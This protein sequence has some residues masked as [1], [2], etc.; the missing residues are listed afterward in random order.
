M[1]E[2]TTC[3]Y[4]ILIVKFDVPITLHGGP[5]FYTFTTV[6]KCNLKDYTYDD[7]RFYDGRSFVE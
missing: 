6:L 1:G 3:F 7:E 5:L 4:N 2:Y